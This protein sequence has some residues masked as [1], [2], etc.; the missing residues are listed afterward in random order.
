MLVYERSTS[1][2]QGELYLTDTLAS[3][4]AGKA[5]ICVVDVANPEDLL[6]FNTPEELLF[7][8]EVFGRRLARRRRISVR[9]PTEPAP[10]V[11][12]AGEWIRILETNSSSLRQTLTQIYGSDQ[13]LLDERRSTFLRV[14]EEFVRR[15]DLERPVVLTRAPGRINLMG[16]HVDHRGGYVNVMAISRE[17]VLAAAARDDDL[18]SL[19]NLHSDEFPERQFHIGSLLQTADWCDWMDFINRHRSTGVGRL[20]R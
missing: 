19:T 16:R 6:A 20:P 9:A 15:Y 5:R 14:L 4:V 17:I 18:V 12:P 11:R 1:N 2:A 13:E 8:E 3:L 10:C 7:A